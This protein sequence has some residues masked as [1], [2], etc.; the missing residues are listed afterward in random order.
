MPFTP[1]SLGALIQ[2]ND[3]TLWHYRTDDLRTAV[4]TPGYFDAGAVGL[5]AGHLMVLHAADALALVPIR[6][7]RTI[8]IGTTLDTFT[9]PFSAVRAVTQSFSVTQ[10]AV[11]VL[12]S[13]VLAPLAAIALAG[14]AIPVSAQV[15]G[16]VAQVVFTLRNGAGTVVPPSRTVTVAAG[17]AEATFPAPPV[18]EGYRVT[19]EDAADPTLRVSG[20]VF[21]VGG[22]AAGAVFRLLL[23]SGFALL[24]EDGAAI[25]T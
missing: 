15:V 9:A 2:G 6:A 23:E 4:A 5:S 20:N 16:P 10:T 8:G 24:A 22:G 18:G 14:S 7:G 25:R 13:L 19:V 1:G 3:F 17:R 21:S 11:A 12:R